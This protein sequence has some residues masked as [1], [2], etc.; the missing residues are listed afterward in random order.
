MNDIALFIP[1]I[2]VAGFYAAII[3]WVY[4]HYT[5]RHR[6]RM[7]LIDAGKD[8]SIFKKPRDKRDRSNALKYGLV[9]IMA[10]LGIVFGNFLSFTGM[11][12]EEMASFSMLLLFG[13]LGLIIFYMITNHKSQQTDS[14]EDII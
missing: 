14:E 3:V 7:A 13:G 4:M 10:G 2:S 6:E 1:I 9:G 8:A 5:S 12:E 11:I